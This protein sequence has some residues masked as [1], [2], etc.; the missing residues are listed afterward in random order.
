LHVRGKIIEMTPSRSKPEFGSFRGLAT[1]TNQDDVP[2]LSFTAFVLMR[3][4]PADRPA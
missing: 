3:R 4:R 2:V 1:V